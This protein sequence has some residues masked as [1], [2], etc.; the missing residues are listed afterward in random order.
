MADLIFSVTDL[1]H[2]RFR[3]IGRG[4]HTINVVLQFADST[5]KLL[6]KQLSI[7]G[8][9]LSERDLQEDYYGGCDELHVY[10]QNLSG[11]QLDFGRFNIQFWLRGEMIGEHLAD[12]V[13][14]RPVDR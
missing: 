3:C 5:D 11:A 10:D 7:T 1:R 13:A 4:K 14:M 2:L 8:L 12:D 9:Q 6:P